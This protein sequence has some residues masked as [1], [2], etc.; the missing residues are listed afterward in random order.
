[1]LKELFHSINKERIIFHATIRAM[2]TYRLNLRYLA[3]RV[4]R[5]WFV[6][7]DNANIDDQL[8]AARF[9]YPTETSV[10][11]KTSLAIF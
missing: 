1:M 7:K 4:L 3:S 2:R 10:R 6:T 9:L 5:R 8:K 11:I